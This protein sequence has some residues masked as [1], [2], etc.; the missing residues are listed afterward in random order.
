[1]QLPVRND[2][3]ATTSPR[4]DQIRR[5]ARILE[6]IQQ[7][8]ISPRHWTRRAL[9]EYHE[10]GERMIQKDLELIRYRMGLELKREDG[11]YFER[12]P[13]L[14]TTTYSFSEAIALLGAARAA[15]ALPGINSSELAAAIARLESIFP[16]NLLPLL[17]EATEQLPQRAEGSHR[18]AMFGLLHRALAERCRVQ[19]VYATASHKGNPQNRVIEPY[20]VIPYGRSWHLVA[21]DHLRQAVITFKV[22]RVQSAEIL[23][24]TYTIPTDFNLDDYL[25]DAWGMMRGAAQP[26]EVVSL[27]FEAPAGQWVSEE[28]W[29]KSQQIENLADGRIRMSLFVGV[30]P[31]MVNWLLYYGEQVYVE[32]PAWLRDKVRERHRL[33]AERC[34]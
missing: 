12:M 20:S 2:T 32:E 22:D 28:H 7:I 4:D 15:Q 3:L 30:T 16:T 14:P 13:H 23:A 21:Y 18:Q 9:A 31:E 25:G 27:L 24:E 19:V 11:Y 34:G 33:A 29:H 5:P 8:A 6:I 10:I 26:A 17:R 1:M